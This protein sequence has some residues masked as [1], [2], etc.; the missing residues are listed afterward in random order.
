MKINL[1]TKLENEKSIADN[2]ISASEKKPKKVYFFISSF[3]E[4]GFEI[5]ESCLIDLKAKKL[6][7][8]GVDKKNTTKKMLEGLYKYTKNIYVYN[9][10]DVVELDSNIVVFE[11]EKKAEIYVLSG[12]CSK[13]GLEDNRSIYTKIEFNLEDKNDTTQF[14]EYINELIKITKTDIV[15]K[16]DKEYILELVDSKEIFSNKQYTHNIMSI[17]ELTK[18][19]KAKSKEENKNI[20]SKKSNAN[21]VNINDNINIEKENTYN[22]TIKLNIVN[23]LDLEDMSFDID[24]GD[25]QQNETKMQDEHDKKEETKKVSK[26]E[27]ELVKKSKKSLKD[28]SD[29][30]KKQ[31]KKQEELD[32]EENFDFDPNSTIDLENMLFEKSDVKLDTKKIANKEKKEKKSKEEGVKE[33]QMTAMNKKI[34]LNKV[35]NI[36]MEL[37]K[38]P[39]KGKDVTAIKL[40]NYIKDMVPK[41]FEAMESSIPVDKKDGLYKEVEISVEIVDTVQ[42]KKYTDVSAVMSSKVGQTYIAFVSDMMK[43]VN[44]EEGDIARLIKLSKEVY[45]IEI[46]SKD[47]QEYKVWKKMCT[48][49]FRGAD[50]QYGV[51]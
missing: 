51:M 2:L 12:N 11:Y 15:R 31:L 19:S 24:V 44:Y 10:N 7:V 32:T 6:F 13:G 49:N 27:K 26:V 35:S 39:S 34:D 5:I 18:E 46:I 45:H 9:N 1:M 37:P 30:E 23:V 38:K 4:T 50:R 25:M 28:E 14:D 17:A 21:T 16:L 47:S 8:I 40:P 48:Q 41:F 33:N 36:V 29:K 22:E 20:E 42:N 3:K 43:N